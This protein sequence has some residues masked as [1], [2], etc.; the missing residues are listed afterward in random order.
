[1]K[2]LNNYLF[3]TDETIQELKEFDEC[4]I[5]FKYGKGSSSKD[6]VNNRTEKRLNL[7]KPHPGYENTYFC[8]TQKIYSELETFTLQKLRENNN[9]KCIKTNSITNNNSEFFWVLE[10]VK[11]I[12]ELVKQW[13]ELK[14]LINEIHYNFYINIEEV[15]QVLSIAQE[16]EIETELEEEEEE[17]ETEN[18]IIDYNNYDN[19]TMTLKKSK[20][21]L[22]KINNLEVSGMNYSRL[23]TKLLIDYKEQYNIENYKFINSLSQEEL[24]NVVNNTYYHLYD[25]KYFRGVNANR[26]LKLIKKLQQ[27]CSINLEL[28][29][30][31]A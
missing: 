25:N 30:K 18:K 31:L 3:I 4:R 23:L 1:M 29:I 22:C 13:Y 16:V 9:F 10:K 12:N 2:F 6:Y 8:E 20:F 26:A 5:K 24:N 21:H 28:K 11:N 27:E 14:K 19:Q 7:N 15:I 17:E